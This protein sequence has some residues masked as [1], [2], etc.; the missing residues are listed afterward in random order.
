MDFHGQ[1]LKKLY[2]RMGWPIDIAQMGGSRSFMTMT[3]TIWWPRSDVWI[4]QIVTGVT[5]VVGVPSTHLVYMPCNWKLI[6]VSFHKL[7]L[8]DSISIMIKKALIIYNFCCVQKFMLIWKILFC[9][10]SKKLKKLAKKIRSVCL[11]WWVCAPCV[12]PRKMDPWWK[13]D[14]GIYPFGIMADGIGLGRGVVW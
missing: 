6:G 3:M 11:L 7:I 9:T 5:S 10:P 13:L 2:L 12:Q 1:I 4:Y 8:D 14:N